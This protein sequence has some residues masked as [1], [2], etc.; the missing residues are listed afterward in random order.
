MVTYED[1][2]DLVMSEG[3]FE[4]NP[5]DLF[6]LFCDRYFFEDCACGWVQTEV[7]RRLAALIYALKT[8]LVT[9]AALRCSHAAEK[10]STRKDD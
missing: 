8:R 1:V 5:N 7:R 2:F 3:G 4:L 6:L 9:T 10:G